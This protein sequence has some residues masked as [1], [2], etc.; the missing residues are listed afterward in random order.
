MIYNVSPNPFTDEMNIYYG[1]FRP[2][3][4]KIE[5]YNMHGQLMANISEKELTAEKY[6]AVWKPNISLTPGVYFCVLKTN[7]LKVHYKKIIKK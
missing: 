7:D 4:I 1:V 3:N 2:A 6:T 5:V